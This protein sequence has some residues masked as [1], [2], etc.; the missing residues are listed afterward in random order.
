[1]WVLSCFRN[2]KLDLNEFDIVKPT[3]IDTT[4]ILIRKGGDAPK[5]ELGL[6]HLLWT[7]FITDLRTEAIY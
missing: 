6:T 7:R 4:L 2:I 3:H 1:M 5:F